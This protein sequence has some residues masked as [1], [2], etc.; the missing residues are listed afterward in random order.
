MI[1]LFF[2]FNLYIIVRYKVYKFVRVFDSFQWLSSNGNKKVEKSSLVNADK[3]PGG[4]ILSNISSKVIY[5]DTSR[6]VVYDPTKQKP[7]MQLTI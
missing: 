3:N 7:G 6:M 5:P 2:F 4:Q 1:F